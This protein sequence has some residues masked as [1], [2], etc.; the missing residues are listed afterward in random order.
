[1]KRKTLG[2]L[3][4]SM[5]ALIAVQTPITAMAEE[6]GGE[7][8]ETQNDGD[9][10]QENEGSIWAEGADL[11]GSSGT[12]TGDVEKDNPDDSVVGADGA[13]AV[14][15][16]DGNVTTTGEQQQ[17]DEAGGQYYPAAVI[18][19]DKGTVNVTGDVSAQNSSAALATGGT[20]NVGGNVT[21]A[22]DTDS[23]AV[24]VESGKMTVEG[25]VAGTGDAAGVVCLEQSEINVNGNVSGGYCGVESD[26]DSAVLVQGDV[27]ADNTDG[28]AVCIMLNQ[29]E[30]SGSVIVLGEA[31]ATGEG[32]AIW[33]DTSNL[34]EEV[35]VDE[36]IAALPDIVVGSLS[37]KNQDYLV[38]INFDEDN[39]ESQDRAELDAAIFEKILY[40]IDVQNPANG[41][42][43]VTGADSA[44]GY[45]TAGENGELV[46]SVSAEQGYELASVSAGNNVVVVRNA[47]G[48]YSVVVPRGG[49]VSISANLR[50]VVVPGQ[51]TQEPSAPQ[52]VPGGQQT[53]VPSAP[54]TVT[55]EQSA[56]APSVSGT[57]SGGN[58]VA[59]IDSV[60][61]YMAYFSFQQS[62]QNKLTK[63]D[64]TNA[65]ME[66]DMGNWI[67]FDRKTFEM[68]AKRSDLTYVITYR[69]DGHKYRVTIPA[70]YPV[71]DLLN[72]DG[73]CGC[74]YLNAVFGSELVQ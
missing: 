14:L 25:N 17:P 16:V 2:F 26:N 19:S 1:M 68:F 56:A 30:G 12:Y 58:S 44:Y 71:M 6:T 39:P 53:A 73:Y 48:T 37:A 8:V 62:L 47:D 41:R 49:G 7:T 60:Q 9:G 34:G 54:Q 28:S 55:G 38:G 24:A 67:S 64:T 40:Y 33:I 72:E 42:I 27:S 29:A 21:S 59:V 65:T 66:I 46:V 74:L 51:E 35:T 43:S 50:A 20:V 69:Y 5:A 10:Q 22:S 57:V 23:A 11:E 31:S 15:T 3:S 36:V 52:T 32:N 63:A 45:M 13:G 4:L 70:G 18:A 61:K